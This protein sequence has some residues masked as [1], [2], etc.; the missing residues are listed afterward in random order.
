MESK[1]TVAKD[2]MF[3]LTI[4]IMFAVNVFNT[5]SHSKSVSAL[6]SQING[7]KDEVIKQLIEN[8]KMQERIRDGLAEISKDAAEQIVETERV[9]TETVINNREIV[10]EYV[11]KEGQ[12][13]EALQLIF[14]RENEL[15]QSIGDF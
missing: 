3:I 7:M 11:E 10:K 5:C 9:H 14:D 1:K 4:I 6:E 2:F 12:D 15:F 13:P 8:N